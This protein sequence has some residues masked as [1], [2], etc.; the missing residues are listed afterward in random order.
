[1]LSMGDASPG[2][3]V[4]IR[5]LGTSW[6]WTERLIFLGWHPS[7]EAY[8]SVCVFLRLVP[9]RILRVLCADIMSVT[10]LSRMAEAEG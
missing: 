6:I 10:S 5:C 9:C 1:M 3:L 7:H 2:D 4:T 8:A